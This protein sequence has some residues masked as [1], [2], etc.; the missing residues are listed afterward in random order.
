MRYWLELEGLTYHMDA[1]E[2]YGALLGA[3]GFVGVRL[4]DD[5]DEYRALA[6]QE[7]ER[8][9]GP[10]GQTL[11][12]ALGPEQ[13]G[14][15]VEDWRMLAVV[16]DNGELRTGRWRA[17]SPEPASCSFWRR[18]CAEDRAPRFTGAARA[19]RRRAVWAWR[20]SSAPG[21]RSPEISPAGRA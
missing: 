21:P 8:L 6:H 13:R 17:A 11:L 20:G 3:S 14:Y 4:T 1:L 16:L 5:S 7:Y 10:L 18:V 2:N 12:E 15:F 19:A 9:R